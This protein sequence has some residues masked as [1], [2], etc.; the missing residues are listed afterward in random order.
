MSL[1]SIVSE[2]LITCRENEANFKGGFQSI[3]PASILLGM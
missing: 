1:K 2:D 3:A